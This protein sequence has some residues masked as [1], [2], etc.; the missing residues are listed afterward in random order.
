MKIV[1]DFD[2]VIC[3][4]QEVMMKLLSDR[5]G[6]TYTL[7]DWYTYNFKESFP[8]C[9]G[10]LGEI[11]KEDIYSD[12]ECEMLEGIDVVMHDLKKRGHDVVV[13]SACA[14]SDVMF[15]KKLWMSRHGIGNIELYP[16]YNG[17]KSGVHCDVMIEDC[18]DN[19]DKSD[20]TMKIIVNKPWN[21]F[22]TVP[23][24]MRAYDAN[25]I[26]MLL[27]NIY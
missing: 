20:A 8:K 11:F 3:K 17:D 26:A 4:S 25:D 9:Y 2:G 1:F 7:D 13:Y 12:N 5:T 21:R 15:G 19:L 14:N 16:I 10:I 22:V 24:V 6:D 18:L 27:N 23:G